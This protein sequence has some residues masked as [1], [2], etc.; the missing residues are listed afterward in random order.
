MSSISLLNNT[1]M[2][3]YLMSSISFNKDIDDIG[4]SYI[5][6]SIIQ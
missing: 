6:S 3:E 2:H 4:Y 5:H 1:T